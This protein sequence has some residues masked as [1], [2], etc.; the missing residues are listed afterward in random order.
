MK[1]D[2]K[3]GCPKGLKIAGWI[4]LGIAFAFLLGFVV[5]WLWNALMPEFFG[6]SEVTYWQGVGL[7]VLARILFG[8]MHSG[9]DSDKGPHRK[10][11]IHEHLSTSDHVKDWHFYDE[12]WQSEGE[13]S[14][15]EF[16]SQERE[17]EDQK[18]DKQE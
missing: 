10:R 9:G 12:W 11:K 6:L 16:A 14:F 1:C 4:V 13:K 18:N 3:H 17:N 2:N 8:G 7:V 15:R 5:K